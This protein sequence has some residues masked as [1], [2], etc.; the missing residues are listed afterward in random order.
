MVRI[1]AACDHGCW[2]RR[3]ACMR[4][5]PDGTLDEVWRARP[6]SPRPPAKTLEQMRA[7]LIEA[8]LLLYPTLSRAEAE[9]EEHADAYM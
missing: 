7:E 2:N 5:K 8:L 3:E 9:E 6:L 4:I 1:A